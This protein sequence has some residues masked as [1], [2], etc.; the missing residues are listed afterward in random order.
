MLIAHI[1]DIHFGRISQEGIVDALVEEV[2]GAE[3]DLV[4][5]SGDLTQRARRWQL[6]QAKE[7]LQRFDGDV[8]VV[9]G[10]HDA[11]AWWYPVHRLTVPVRRYRRYITPD[12][13][14]TFVNDKVAVL[15]ISSV[16][17]WTVKAGLVRKRDRN[18]IRQFFRSVDDSLFKVLVVHHHL[19][20]MPEF[21]R[22]DVSLF[23]NRTF[24][25]LQE[26]GVDMV[27]SG[28]LHRSHLEVFRKD[29]PEQLLVASAGTATSN[30]GRYP[31]KL[32][33][34]YNLIRIDDKKIEVDERRFDIDVLQYVSERSSAFDRPGQ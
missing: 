20:K 11:Y 12:L 5:V 32:E 22:H 30:R 1:S 34:H 16:H 6:A 18:R 25:I 27:L 17:G 15:G 33:N 13:S 19:V 21:G 14:P 10:N 9:P 23:G 24:G 28:H 8:L 4:V 26:E 7:M 2:N 31:A 29:T 3:A